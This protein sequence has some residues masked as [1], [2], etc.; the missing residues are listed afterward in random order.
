MN[1][2]GL[3]KYL[4]EDVKPNILFTHEKNKFFLI[5]ISWD[6]AKL[7]NNDFWM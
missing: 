7:R 3:L 6:Q 1:I 5:R 4:K 2:L